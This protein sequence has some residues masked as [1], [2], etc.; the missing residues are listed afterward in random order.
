MKRLAVLLSLS[1][2]VLSGCIGSPAAT[3]A[4]TPAPT[5]AVVPV[6]AP[7][8]SVPF[9]YPVI[10]STTGVM[11]DNVLTVTSA[12]KGKDDTYI[13]YNAVMSAPGTNVSKVKSFGSEL[14]IPNSMIIPL[15]KGEKVKKG[16]IVLT[17]WQ[18]GSGMERAI[19]TG[20]TATQP[21][22]RY[23][24]MD[25]NSSSDKEDTLQPDTFVKIADG[26]NAGVT[27]GCMDA[28]STNYGKYQILNAT[29]SKVLV[30]GWAGSIKTFD[31]SK[32]FVVPV[33]P[34]V[35]VGDSVYIPNYGSFTAGKVKKVDAALGRVTVTYSFGGQDTDAAVA[36]G[37]VATK[38]GN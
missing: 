27:V 24:D 18:S 6:A 14:S 32:C 3:P 37:D 20:G 15:P 33:V 30:G 26:W 12:L 28:T 7:E 22:V 23:L 36:Y 38:L 17:W 9:D 4:T 5:A 8:G 10:A 2:L 16:D 1:S 34:T 19:V 25:A 13:Y 29:D 11:G 21:T 35:K 31:R